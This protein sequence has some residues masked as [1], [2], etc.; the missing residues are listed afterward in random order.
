MIYDAAEHRPRAFALEPNA[1]ERGK[2]VMLLADDYECL[3]QERTAATRETISLA[4]HRS[5]ARE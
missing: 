5:T 4:E 3:A 2:C 1:G